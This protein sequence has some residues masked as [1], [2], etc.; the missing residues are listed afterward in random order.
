[1]LETEVNGQKESEQ[2]EVSSNNEN[3]IDLTKNQ[4]DKSPILDLESLTHNPCIS[5]VYKSIRMSTP[6]N[7]VMNISEW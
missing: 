4:D 3:E 2:E 6:V 5:K 7:T 1:M